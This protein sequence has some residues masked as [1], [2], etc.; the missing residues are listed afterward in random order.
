MKCHRYGCGKFCFDLFKSP[1]ERRAHS[2]ELVHKGYFGNAVFFGLTP[3][4]LALGFDSFHSAENNDRAVAHPYGAFDLGG[5]IYMPGSIDQVYEIF[6]TVMCPLEACGGGGYSYTPAALF[7]KIIHYG[8]A[9]I[10]IA[11][12]VS[13]ARV[14][15]ETLGDCG[16]SGIDM[17]YD[18]D[19]A[20]GFERYCPAGALMLCHSLDSLNLNP[21][22]L[23]QGI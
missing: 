1:R 20:Y 8:I 11:Y 4:L 22:I 7:V 19:I 13:A 16:F 21:F 15:E 12:P 2:V 3:D 18:A 17:G 10:D 9:G 14:I 5:K 6:R 23:S